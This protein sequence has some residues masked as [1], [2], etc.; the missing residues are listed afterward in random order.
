MSAQII[1]IVNQKGGTGKTTTTVNL[2]CALGKLGSKVMIVDFDSQASLT[3]YLGINHLPKGSIADVVFG[4]KDL[5]EILVKKEGVTIVPANM[6]LADAELSLAKYEARAEVL[7]R[8]L[9]QVRDEYDYILIDCGPSLSVLTLNAL[10]ASDGVIIPLELEVLAMQGLQL[11][12]KT[13]QRVRKSFNPDIK[14]L[15]ILLLKV[16]LAKKITQ[17]VYQML[18]NSY[19]EHIFKAHIELDTR[20]IEAPSFGQSIISYA[21][22]SMASIGYLDLAMELMSGKVGK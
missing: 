17:E 14:I 1:S 7:K 22:E 9:N 2:G 18:I 19:S 21:P 15:G 3:Y 5:K 11:I 12:N 13:I 8:M 16:D 6:D 20:A 10:N 4:E